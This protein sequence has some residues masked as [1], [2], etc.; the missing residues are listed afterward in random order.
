MAQDIIFPEWL[1]SNALRNYPI[2]EN[3]SRTDIS[4]TFTIPNSLI[5]SAQINYGRVFI[6]G[7]FYISGLIVSESFV[8][9][10]ISYQDSNTAVSPVQISSVQIDASTFSQYTYYPFVGQ[11]VNASVIGSLAIG[12]LDDTVT[13]GVGQFTFLPAATALEVNTQF[14][15]VPALESVE[16]YNPS[17]S[18]IYTATDILRLKAGKNVRLTYEQLDGDNFGVIR[19]DAI[20]GENLTQV[21]DCKNQQELISGP[22]RQIN[23]VGPDSSGNFY[24]EGSECIQIVADPATNSIKVVDL[25]SQSCCGCTELEILTTALEQL[26][27]QEETLKNLIS[28]T[29]GQQSELLAQLIA[30]L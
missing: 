13:E 16:V 2:Q 22:I 25:C 21:S 20:N 6:G 3:A 11:G 7:T 10:F 18:L 17:N 26:R 28:S 8:T 27:T 14:V 5:V 4:G 15:S 1:N 9:I 24:I 19:I 29:Q 23:G 30:N 12:Q